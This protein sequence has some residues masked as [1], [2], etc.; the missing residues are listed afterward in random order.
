MVFLVSK[1]TI[2]NYPLKSPIANYAALT[3]LAPKD[4]H[5]TP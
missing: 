5:L 3:G 1:S 2:S 4:E